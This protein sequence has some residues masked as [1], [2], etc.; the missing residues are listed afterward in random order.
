[1]S[2]SPILS[3]H[4]LEY[5]ARKS[6]S[7]LRKPAPG[8]EQESISENPDQI[9]GFMSYQS[10]F[11]SYPLLRGH[12]STPSDRSDFYSWAPIPSNIIYTRPSTTDTPLPVSS[13]IPD[14]RPLQLLTL[15]KHFDIEKRLCKYEV[16]GGGACRDDK[17]EDL[18]LSKSNGIQ[19]TGA[20]L[21]SLLGISLSLG[22]SMC[23]WH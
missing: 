21:A 15:G 20:C 13:L 10:P 4:H 9:P 14:L 23:H 17:C 11:V 16:P 2:R 19:P 8:N 22:A 3:S 12:A 7:P 1:M 5:D 18:H 6:P